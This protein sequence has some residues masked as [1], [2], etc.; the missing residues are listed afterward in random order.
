[1][2]PKH[3]CRVTNQNLEKDKVSIKLKVHGVPHHVRP[4]T[5]ITIFGTYQKI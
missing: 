2:D 4:R 1:M 3:Y 5:E